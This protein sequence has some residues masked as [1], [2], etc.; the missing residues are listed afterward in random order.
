MIILNRLGTRGAIH[1]ITTAFRNICG[2]TTATIYSP[3]LLSPQTQGEL[4]DM[5]ATATRYPWGSDKPS[6]RL[7]TVSSRIHDRLTKAREP[8]YT[9]IQRSINEVIGEARLLVDA[10]DFLADR[11]LRSR[12]A[13][14][15]PIDHSEITSANQAVHKAVAKLTTSSAIDLSD[16]YKDLEDSIK[17]LLECADRARSN[18]VTASMDSPTENAWDTFTS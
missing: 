4:F 6:N 13:D 7:R 12:K 16:C 11:G 17:L 15:K 14:A 10:L 3:K 5:Q 2:C 18:G 1:A 8:S 9:D